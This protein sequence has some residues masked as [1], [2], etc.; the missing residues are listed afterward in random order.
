M[1]FRVWARTYSR[2]SR[3]VR[4]EQ[5]FWIK[6]GRGIEHTLLLVD[7]AETTTMS[8]TSSVPKIKDWRKAKRVASKVWWHAKQAVLVKTRQDVKTYSYDFDLDEKEAEMT[9][10]ARGDRRL[11]ISSIKS[12]ISLGKRFDNIVAPVRRA[13][14]RHS[15]LII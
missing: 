11:S 4:P 14:S 2:A 9:P 6:S 10:R 15:F 3:K 5:P 13:V 12:T 8:K 7:P 1:H